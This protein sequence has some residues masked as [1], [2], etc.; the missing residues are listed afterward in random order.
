MSVTAGKKRKC[1]RRK[2]EGKTRGR[3]L[4]LL[5]SYISPTL[6]REK[7]GKEKGGG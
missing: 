3:K 5:P 6:G 2:G 4:L 7:E 1:G